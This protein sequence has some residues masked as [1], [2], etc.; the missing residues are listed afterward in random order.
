VKY[1]LFAVLL[2][3]LILPGPATSALDAPV[4]L[5]AIVGKEGGIVSV[6]SNH[7]VDNER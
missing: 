5:G 6:P 1:L 2:T 7:S 3:G 4:R